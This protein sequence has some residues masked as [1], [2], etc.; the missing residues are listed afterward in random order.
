MAGVFLA[1]LPAAGQ[2]QMKAEMVVGS[3]FGRISSYSKAYLEKAARSY[4]AGLKSGNA[5]VVEASIAYS[6]FLKVSAPHL[7]LS[8][9]RRELDIVAVSGST[10]VLRY[11]AY[12]ATMVFENPA[13][14]KN[15]LGVGDPDGNRFFTAVAGQVSKALLGYQS[16]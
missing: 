16:E 9:I 3:C 8:D 10:P 14:F 7:D 11:K 2:S 5:G 15:A 12:L 6:T 1:A 4:E 13:E